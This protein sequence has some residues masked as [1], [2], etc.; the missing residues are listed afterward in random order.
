MERYDG[1]AAT[2]SWL[3][4]TIWCDDATLRAHSLDREDYRRILD[5]M[6]DADLLPATYEKWRYR[7]DRLERDIQRSGGI[8][9]RAKID[10]DAFVSWC[11]ARGLNVDADARNQFAGEVAY[12][13]V[14]QSH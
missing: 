6:A 7:A 12:S 8:A 13:A 14:G 3:G 10:P 9:V 11:T 5:V 1:V 2:S 4:L